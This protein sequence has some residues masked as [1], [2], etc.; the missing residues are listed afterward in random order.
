[1][2]EKPII[3]GVDESPEAGRAALA[4]W[5]L[6]AAMRAPCRLIHAIPD[7][8][9]GAALEQVPITP[10]VS[11]EIADDARRRIAAALGPTLPPDALAAVEVKVGRPAAVLAE[12]AAGAQLVVLG[13]RM[14]GPLARGLGGSTAHYLVRSLDVPVLVIALD[15][16][17][18]RRVLAAVDLSFASEPTIAAARRLAQDMDARLRVLHVVE[19]VRATRAAARVDE[20]AVYRDA[21]QSFSQTTAGLT[22]LAAG[23]RAM[24][25]GPA[26]DTVAAEAASWAADVVVVGSHGKG[27]VERLLVG[28]VTER[29]LARLPAS[30]LIVPVRPAERPRSWNGKERRG[31]KG[32]RKGVLVV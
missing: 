31:R 28:S 30:L 7:V 1:M 12:A 26:A 8:W 21:L 14:H 18:I 19:P 11:A 27:W 25:R 22:E 16:W 5:R 29:L 4:G 10:S 15:G 2:T 23:D 20:D 13:A 3:V 32:V 9:S 24:R 17:P 6:A